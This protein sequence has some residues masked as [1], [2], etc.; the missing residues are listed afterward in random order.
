MAKGGDTVKETEAQKAFADVASKNWDDYQ[1]R[2]VP[3]QNV[4]KQRVEQ[5]GASKP[6]AIGRAAT[7]VTGEFGKARTGLDVSNASRGINVGSGRGIFGDANLDTSQASSKSAVMGSADR[8]I[9]EQYFKGLTD[10]INIGRGEK[11]SAEFGS[12]NLANMSAERARADAQN[13]QLASAGIGSGIGTAVGTAGGI[14][15]NK[16][17]QPSI[18][19]PP[20]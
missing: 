14:A 1:R 13:S 12:E 15:L 3:V 2:W 10:V 4:F 11:A 16:M 19:A 18:T 7:D 5:I 17:T 6:V 8:S 20:I 9:D